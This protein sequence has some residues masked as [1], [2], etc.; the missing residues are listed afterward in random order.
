MGAVF[1]PSISRQDACFC[2]SPRPFPC[3]KLP[4]ERFSPSTLSGHSGP[5]KIEASA[6]GRS[7]RDPARSTRHSGSGKCTIS[8]EGE[9]WKISAMRDRRTRRVNRG[10]LLVILAG[11]ACLR[12]YY[13]DQPFVDERAGV[14]QMTQ[15]S[16]T[17]FIGV[18]SIYFSPRSA[19][20]ALVRITSVMSFN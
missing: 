16:L 8:N 1:S 6:T 7:F 14:R 3:H 13:I 15:L 11:A 12:L 4:R 2:Y 5:V 10:L 20:T 17:I 18:N 19:G 9:K